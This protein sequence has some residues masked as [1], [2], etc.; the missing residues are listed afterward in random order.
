MLDFAFYYIRLFPLLLVAIK[1][2]LDES[3]PKKGISSLFPKQLA[4]S[5]L[6]NVISKVMLGLKS[7]D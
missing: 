5:L 1:G 3:N 6:T 2:N 7:L 4:T